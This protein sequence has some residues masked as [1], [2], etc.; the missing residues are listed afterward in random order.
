MK[1]IAVIPARGGSKG[2][3]GKNLL[4][5]AGKAL[6]VWSIEQALA[7]RDVIHR[8][9]VSTDSEEIAKV[10]VDSGC[11]GAQSASTHI[12]PEMKRR[13]S[14]C[15]FMWL[16]KWAR[17]GESPDAVMLL[18]PT[19]PLRLPGSIERAVAEFQ[20]RDADSLISMVETHAFFWSFPN[21][22]HSPPVAAY[23]FINR[24]RRQE[25]LPADK[26]YKENGSNYITRTDLLCTKKN[27]LGGVIAGFIMGEAEGLEIDSVADFSI[28][29]S[30][31]HLYK[32][33]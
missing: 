2:V 6:I 12:L 11:G 21:G 26:K 4:P 27:R 15:F 32:M 23:D 1:I 13:R 14:Q 16:K 20:V 29:E 19:S 7:A 18:Q 17:Q 3:P 28:V 9:V 31:L 24:P 30:L 25:I 22:L 33:T 10:A 8:V 5:L